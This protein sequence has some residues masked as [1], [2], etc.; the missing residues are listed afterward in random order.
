MKKV[1]IMIGC[2]GSGKS[3]W[4]GEHELPFVSRDKVRIDLGFCGPDEKYLGTKEEEERVTKEC[5]K[6]RKEL[7][8][9]GVDF[10]IDDTNVRKFRREGLIRELREAG[11]HVVGVWMK[12]KL[13]DCIERRRGEIPGDAISRMWVSSRDVDPSEF[14]ELIEV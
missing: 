5:D 10:A 2:P 4:V 14:D 7:I 3:T 9:E 11:Y 13:E 12:T 8:K 1:F 6:Q